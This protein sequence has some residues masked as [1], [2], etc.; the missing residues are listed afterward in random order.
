MSVHLSCRLLPVALLAAAQPVHAQSAPA[1]L[2]LSGTVRVRYEAI[3][4]QARAGFNSSDDLLNIRSTLLADYDAGA[5]RIAGEVW[6]SRV[7]G[8][9]KGS[10]VSAN[11]VNTL[12]LV[13]AFVE[14][15]LGGVAGAGS[16]TTIQAGRFTVNLGSRRLVAA[17]DYRNTTNG[18][19]GVRADLATKT[20]WHA[21]MLYTLPQMRR[22]DDLAAVRDN[23][24]G[25]DKESFDLVLWGGLL[26]RA[27]AIGHATAEASFFHLGERDTPGRP[28]RDR[29]L[30]TVS[31]R[32]IRDPAPATTDFELEA[33]AQW[34][35]TSTGTAASAPS[36]RVGAWFVHAEAGRTFA[37]P[38]KPH[39]SIE[40]DQASGDR[41]G[42]RNGRFDTLFGM[43]RADFAP[44]GLYNAIARAN[45]VTPGIRIEVT[46][47]KRTDW[48]LSYRPMW[49]AS[50]TDAFS[51]TG[52]RDPTG[53]SGSFAG[54][55]L[56]ARL[57]HQLT[58]ALRLE[59]DTTLL[60]KG[61][62]LR[63][64]PNATPGAW[65]RYV[66]LNATAAF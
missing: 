32:L 36:Q 59:L 46:P 60:R 38:W 63:D 11:D 2:R 18:Y 45:I 62:F 25:L 58:K 10:P 40:Y 3:D 13:Q 12:E 20:G 17:D 9:D 43:R 19:T 37:G 41:P 61:R 23:K 21:T 54:H 56:D 28:T 27:R 44:A 29:S 57:R 66:S 1:K 42:G 15:R 7:Y 4:G 24:V 8:E 51:T 5:I 14:A 6:D 33:I 16:T 47:S 65:T 53:R 35:T 49:L 55:Q 31:L 52:V 34:G 50:R 39:L 48:F 22:P 64:A 26:A 30:D